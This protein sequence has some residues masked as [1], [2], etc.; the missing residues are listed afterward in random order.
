MSV[1]DNIRKQREKKNLTQKDLGD[2]LFVTPQAVSRWENGDVEPSLDTLKQMAT[3]FGVSVDKLVQDQIEATE[4]K[5][6]EPIVEPA[7]SKEAV[8]VQA[9]RLLGTCKFCGKAIYEGDP[10]GYGH[11]S[12][13][14]TGRRRQK[15]SSFVLSSTSEGQQLVCQGCLNK[16]S[17]AHKAAELMQSEALARRRSTTWGWSIFAG[18]LGFIAAIIAAVSCQQ[19]GNMSSAIALYCLSPL[20]A[21]AAFALIFV[22][23]NDNTFVSSL[24]YGLSSFAFMKMPQLIFCLNFDGLVFLIIAKLLLGLIAA[25][26][27]V[28]VMG[29]AIAFSSLFAM[30]MFPVSLSREPG[31]I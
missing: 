12:V 11:E 26:L 29:F 25:T 31:T 6:V 27:F 30:F 21:Y 1:G 5:A 17:E 28:L 15:H 20:F 7:P 13:R 9:P 3:I 14:Y 23:V 18:V 22:L 10:H 4:E 19:G 16:I 8:P 2:Q 24:F